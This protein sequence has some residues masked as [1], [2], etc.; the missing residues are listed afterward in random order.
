[1]VDIG[2]ILGIIGILVTIIFGIPGFFIFKDNPNVRKVIYLI[3]DKKILIKL[4][5]IK[6]YSIFEWDS[7][8]ISNELIENLKQSGKK[9]ER[10]DVG[11]N[12]IRILIE[13]TTAPYQIKILPSENAEPLE[14]DEDTKDIYLD[15]IIDFEGIIETG[16]RE[17]KKTQEYLSYIERFYKVIE[18][19]YGA[20]PIYEDYDLVSTLTDF[21]ETWEV[22]KTKDTENGKVTIGK[23]TIEVH[24]NTFSSLYSDCKKNITLI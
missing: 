6:R 10:I 16:Y 20:S 9:I 18:K 3:F 15:V 24:S 4:S 11:I 19:L 12:Y 22:I 13:N 1:M 17:D 7:K 23:K 14:N 8:D 5:S 2:I 21:N